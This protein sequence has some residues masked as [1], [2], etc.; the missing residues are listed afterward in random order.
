M[1]RMLHE[2]IFS[3]K[4]IRSADVT[5]RYTEITRILAIGLIELK[6]IIE[7]RASLI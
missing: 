3:G 4:I 7:R 2:D 1:L 5:T 6:R